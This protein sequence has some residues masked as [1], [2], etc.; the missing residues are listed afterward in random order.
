LGR[1]DRYLHVQYR[2]VEAGP[3]VAVIKEL[4]MT[5][6]KDPFDAIE[7]STV[8]A[9][10]NGRRLVE[11]SMILCILTSHDFRMEVDALSSATGFDFGIQEVLDVGRRAVNQLRVFNFRHG[12]TRAMETPS[13]RYGSVPVDGPQAGKAIMPYWEAALRN[14]YE[15]MGWDPETGKPLPETL[16]KLGLAHLVCFEATEGGWHAID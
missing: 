15:R 8:N 14:Y 7:A 2:S 6:L 3:G 13:V 12:L 10:V 5:P 11:D 4:G 16:E 9:M 1:D